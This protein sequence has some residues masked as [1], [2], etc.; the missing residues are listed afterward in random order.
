MRTL[1]S[2]LKS[3]ARVT[4]VI[5]LWFLLASTGYLLCLNR[6]LELP[7]PAGA[8]LP[9]LA[10]GYLTQAVGIGVFLIAARQRAF[11]RSRRVVACMLCLY[12]LTLGYVVFSSDYS[13]VFAAGLLANVFAGMFQGFYLMLLASHVRRPSRGTVFGCGYAA[14]TLLT[15]LMSFP[16]N[17]VLFSGTPCLACCSLLALAVLC[18]LSSKDDFMTNLK[19]E[20]QRATPFPETAKP[21]RKRVLLVG[22][23]L[24]V[25]CFAHAI[26]FSFPADALESDVNLELSRVLYGLGIACVGIAADHD[27]RFA[28]VACA[29]SLVM[30]FLLLSLTG[31][32]AASALLWS[33]GYLLTGAYVLFSVLLVVDLAEDAGRFDQAGAGMLARYAGDA[34][35]ASLCFALSSNPVALIAVASA[36]F[37]FAVALLVLLYLQVLAPHAGAASEERRNPDPVDLFAARYSLTLRERDVLRLVIGEKTNAE[38]AAE[39]VITERTVKFHMSNL[40]KKTGCKTRREVMGQFA[41]QENFRANAPRGFGDRAPQAPEG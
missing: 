29:A 22:L 3:N 34:A 6:I 18:L 14:S 13:S 31:A 26:G 37:S 8:D 24:V 9:L 33:L 12:L 20:D 11:Y 4:L 40:L 19:N 38:I 41:E 25:A 32:G 15:L 1:L 21:D 16:G 30:P 7:G 27:R 28:L 36:A 23:A 17:G 5:C 10:L 39:L 2:T 35:G